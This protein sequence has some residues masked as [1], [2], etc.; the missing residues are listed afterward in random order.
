[1]VLQTIFFLRFTSAGLRQKPET[2]S[3]FLQKAQI[4][5]MRRAETLSLE[6]W[7]RLTADF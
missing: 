1:M 5:P 7:A 2:V 4:D 3:A 6:E